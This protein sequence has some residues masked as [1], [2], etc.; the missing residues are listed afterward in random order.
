MDTEVAKGWPTCSVCGRPLGM[1][2]EKDML[3][4]SRVTWFC[5]FCGGP[6]KSIVSSLDISEDK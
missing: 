2:E 1:T 4:G 3:G 5:Q 6:A